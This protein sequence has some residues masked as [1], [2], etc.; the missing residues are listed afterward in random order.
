MITI[1]RV[2]TTPP[3]RT[4][5]LT[6]LRPRTICCR[7]CF[8]SVSLLL[9]PFQTFISTSN[10]LPHSSPFFIYVLFYFLL[11]RRYKRINP[12]YKTSTPPSTTVR[13][14][15]STIG[16]SS[17]S[18][19]PYSPPRRPIL[20]GLRPQVPVPGPIVRLPKRDPARQRFRRP[21]YD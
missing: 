1:P 20:Y 6:P 12:G 16:T 3:M 7:A 10:H 15:P 17:T 5:P 19:W 8:A 18:R 4:L 13:S 2:K 9:S 11:D 21:V 14:S